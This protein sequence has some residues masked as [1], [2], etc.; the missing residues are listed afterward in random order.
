MSGSCMVWTSGC[1][2]VW[3]SVCV[4]GGAGVGGVGGGGGRRAPLTRTRDVTSQRGFV[5]LALTADILLK[6]SRALLPS[7]DHGEN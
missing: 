7:G 1:V 5:A 4:C 3:I 2:R 6:N